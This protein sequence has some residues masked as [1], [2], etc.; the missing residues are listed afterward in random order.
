MR[1]LF[2]LV[3]L[4]LGSGNL[5]FAQ[6]DPTPLDNGVL[7]TMCSP[8]NASGNQELNLVLTTRDV[9]ACADAYLLNEFVRKGEKLTWKFKGVVQDEE[10]EEDL[11]PV[12][13]QVSLRELPPNDYK[14]R[15]V[16]NM[17]VFRAMLKVTEE[18]YELRSDADPELLE[19]ENGRLNRIP[20][21]MICGSVHYTEPAQ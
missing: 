10:C 9:Y 5:V 11:G 6:N 21:G 1:S 14:L 15:I 3:L 16:I 19:I 12:Q 18:Y 4:A 20:A 13:A 7:S 8:F 2:L 17:Q